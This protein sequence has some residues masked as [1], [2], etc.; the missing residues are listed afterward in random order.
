[1][2]KAQAQDDEAQEDVDI[3]ELEDSLADVEKPKELRPGVYLG[4]VQDVQKQTSGKGNQYYAIKIVIAPDEVPADTRD[5]FPDG[6]IL[7]WNRQVVPKKGDRRALFN[8]R[9]LYEAM[10]LSSNVTVIDTSEWMGCQV[11]VRVRHKPWEGELRA[12]IQ[13]LEAAEAP[14]RGTSKRKPQDQEEDQ[15]EDEGDAAPARGRKPAG[16]PKG[17]GR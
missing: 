12:E 7:Y 5:D 9:K 11:R 10:G 1:M 4:E 16:K 17:R 2:A 8:M 6:V 3:I 14:A 15:E 13:S